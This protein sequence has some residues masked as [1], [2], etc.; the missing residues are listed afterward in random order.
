M[1]TQNSYEMTVTKEVSWD[2]SHRLSKHKG[3]CKNLHGHTY[4]LQATFGTPGGKLTDGMLADFK[5]IKNILEQ[6]VV[7]KLDH[8]CLLD[9]R[10]DDTKVGTA[11]KELGL[12]LI[13]LDCEPT[14]ENMV[15]QIANWIKE[16][17][18]NKDL[19][20]VKLKLWETPTSFVEVTF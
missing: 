15:L 1:C 14:A 4:K 12:K 20:L 19:I 7:S 9:G 13:Y 3:L 8:G 11:L 10:A 2:M 18:K 5:D 16:V 17:N 6:A